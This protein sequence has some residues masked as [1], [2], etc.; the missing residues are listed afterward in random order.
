M[1]LVGIAMLVLGICT[2]KQCFSQRGDVSDTAHWNNYRVK[3]REIH[4]DNLVR[5]A[6]LE[7]YRS[8]K[9]D[10]FETTAC[11]RH[12]NPHN[13]CEYTK[14]NAADYYDDLATSFAKLKCRARSLNMKPAKPA[15]GKPQKVCN[16]QKVR[17]PE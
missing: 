4:V 1:K 11:Y 14:S 12:R 3:Y 5:I 2:V 8:Q 10:S 7:C 15:K 16:W 13:D 6:K 9:P 17:C